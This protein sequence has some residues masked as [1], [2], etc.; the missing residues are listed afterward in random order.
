[1]DPFDTS[2]PEGG[3]REVPPLLVFDTELALSGE[4]VPE[5]L[6]ALPDRIVVYGGPEPRQPL[7]VWPRTSV[8]AVR[9]ETSVG[10][11]Y[12][13]LRCGEHWQDIVRCAGGGG[14]FHRAIVEQL[15]AWRRG[16]LRGPLDGAA[17]RP[18]PGSAGQRR[19]NWQAVKRI[20]KLLYPF[21]GVAVLL[22]GLSLC[23]VVIE[24]APPILTRF[25]VDDVL[26]IDRPRG[27]LHESLLLLLAIVLGLLF[28]RITV[29]LVALWKARISSRVGTA[30]TASL[31]DELVRKLNDLPLSFH[32][33]NQVGVLMSRVSYD[34]ET[35]HTLVHHMTGGLLLQMMQL[36]GIG[37]MLFYLNA[38]L[39][40][41]TMLPMPFI[42]IAS[43]YFTRYLNPRHHH[44][45][46]AVGKQA[47]ALSGMLS[48]IRV[49][50]A[51]VQEDREVKRFWDFSMRLRDSRQTV[52]Y[53]TSSFTALMGFLFA[54]GGLAVWYIGGRAVLEDQMTLG[55]LMAFFG[56]L[57]MFYSPL[58]SI[59]ESTTWFSNLFTASQRITELLDMPGETDNASALPSA[60]PMEGRV[61][62]DNVSFSYH[63]DQPV[64]RN[65][66]LTIEPGERVGIVG[67]SGSGKSTL[68][69]LIAGLY[70]VDSGRILVDGVD[71]REMNSR[72]LRRH[73]GMVLQE[74]FLFRGSVAVNMAYGSTEATPEQILRAARYADAHD[75]VM[76]MPFAYDTQL[77]EGGSGLSG[78]ER[79]RLSIARAMVFDPKILILDEA[80]ASVDAESERSIREAVWRFSRRRT[81][82]SIAHRLSTLRGVDRIVVLDQGRLLE[83]G[84]PEE[85][86]AQDG[87][88]SRLVKIQMNTRQNREQFAAFVGAAAGSGEGG[89]DP[90]LFDG[91]EGA[92]DSLFDAEDDEDAGDVDD[93]FGELQWLDPASTEIRPADREEICVMR[94]GQTFEGVHALRTFPARHPLEYIS[95]RRRDADGRDRELGLIRDLVDWPP[96]AQQAVRRS[97]DRRYLLRPI[98]E[99]KQVHTDRLGLA[100]LV[101]TDGGLVRFSLDRPA[102]NAVPFGPN[103]LLLLD[104]TGTFYVIPDRKALPARQQQLLELYCAE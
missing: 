19:P 60:R 14:D 35:F 52:D 91:S 85:L 51:F 48:G 75:F 29:T 3:A 104:R 72:Q 103:G 63:N 18:L 10:S 4:A 101:M 33:R 39:A 8:E 84:T 34:T 49:V 6:V 93:V 21:R 96:A 32:D 62:F 76:R 23:T 40:L 92:E 100:F 13:Q 70:R 67:R 12:L 25:L 53:S 9:L 90:S 58:T 47:S 82:V 7:R 97:L 16:E 31:R 55:S 94:D 57:A 17:D 15:N 5:R 78:G 86:L 79:Q 88:Y 27:A 28:F 38:K 30:I 54:L 95:L 68:V 36:V 56:Y 11:C 2:T 102:E 1:M 99:I 81:T 24:L 77:G 26:Q 59:S 87:L 43:A 71:I 50:K 66:T 65:L 61:E 69:N 46:E 44:Y 64:L 74:P 41:I 22:F 83:Q 42:L 73:I 45:W 89:F 98:R 80:T 37:V 20:G